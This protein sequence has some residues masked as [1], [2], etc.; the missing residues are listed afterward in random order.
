MT[1]YRIY[2][3]SNFTSSSV[4]TKLGN[5][6]SASLPVAN[7][8]GIMT[9]VGMATS[10]SVTVEGGGDLVLQSLIPGQIYPCYPT[11]IRVSMGTGSV[12]S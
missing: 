10:G 1:N 7:A 3:V 6:A 11:A 5:E 12:L 9:P 4:W 8:W 2:K